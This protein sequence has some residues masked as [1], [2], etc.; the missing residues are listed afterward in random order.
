M[1]DVVPCNEYKM[2]AQDR[3]SSCPHS[4]YNLIGEMITE[5]SYLIIFKCSFF[6][7]L[8]SQKLGCILNPWSLEITIGSIFSFLVSA[9]CNTVSYID[10]ISLI[11]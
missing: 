1:P 2:A 5:T 9:Y 3:Y 10:S 8:T 7:H 4:A 6:F 11:K